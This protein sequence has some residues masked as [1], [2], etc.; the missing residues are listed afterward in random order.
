M[1]GKILVAN[2]DLEMA[3]IIASELKSESSQIFTVNCGKKLIEKIRLEDFQLLIMDYILPELS[4]CALLDQIRKIKNSDQ[5][6]ILILSAPL[7]DSEVAEA[8]EK[9]ANDFLFK[10]YQRGQLVSRVESL[11]GRFNSEEEKRV[12]KEGHYTFGKFRLNVHSSDFY[13]DDVRTHLTPSEFKLLETLFRRR[14]TI[15]TRDQLIEEVQ[16]AGVVVVDRAIDTH[17]FSLRKKLGEFSN[18]IETVRGIG[19]RISSEHDS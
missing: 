13:Q 3:S 18:L 15:L 7:E 6:A 4:G 12:K 17:V 14:G 10:P 16:G 8:I 9:G 2:R 11:N 19:Y 1:G 5:L